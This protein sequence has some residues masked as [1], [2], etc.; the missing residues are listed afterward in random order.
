M[1]CGVPFKIFMEKWVIAAKK[2]DFKKTAELFHI[3]QVTARL[4]RNREVIGEEAIRRY[5]H[6]NLEELP[7]WKPVSYTHLHLLDGLI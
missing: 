4:I 6:G 3:D 7:S 2:A 5:L 1:P